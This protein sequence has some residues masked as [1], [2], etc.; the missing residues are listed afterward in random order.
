MSI[1][2]PSALFRFRAVLPVKADYA[3]SAK[4]FYLWTVMQ[5]HQ[6]PLMDILKVYK[7]GAIEC[8]LKWRKSYGIGNSLTG[9]GLCLREL[10]WL[11][12]LGHLILHSSVRWKLWSARSMIG[13]YLRML[14][15]CSWKSWSLTS[16]DCLPEWCMHHSARLPARL[17]TADQ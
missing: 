14:M 12:S 15:H 9:L 13:L 8:R 4:I 16:P 5:R 17:F 6:W 3:K 11:A 10:Q 7:Y 2:D 1:A